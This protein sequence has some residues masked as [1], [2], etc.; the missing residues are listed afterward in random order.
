MTSNL[1]NQIGI[2]LSLL[3][4]LL[5]TP[6]I[7]NLI[8]VQQFDNKIN[9]AFTRFEMWTKFPLNFHPPSWKR[10][11][12]YAQ[13]E[14]I[15]PITSVL[16]L[17]FSLIW[18]STL[19][20]G[21][22]FKLWVFIVLSLITISLT[23]LSHLRTLSLKG[24]KINV[25]NFIFYFLFAFL[26]LTLVSPGGSI[27]RIGMLIVRRLSLGIKRLFVKYGGLRNLL[28]AFAIIAFILSNLLQFIATLI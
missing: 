12:S 22:Y 19:F 16:G 10:T 9:D 17:I 3:S 13:R 4:G 20:F 25:L 5:L 6:E 26:I 1:L 23:V 21:I 18:I 28:I 15:E 7:F 27:L 11:L 24:Y 14:A 8:P 2:V